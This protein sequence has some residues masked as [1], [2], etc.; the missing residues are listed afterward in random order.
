[1]VVRQYAPLDL[2]A[3]R[4]R[5]LS[6]KTTLIVGISLAVHAAVAGYLAM[7]QFAPPQAAPIEDPPVVQLDFYTPP[8]PPPPP[9]E[10]KAPQQPPKIQ[11]HTPVPSPL[12][13]PVAP[14]P[15][16]PT[17][18]P[19]RAI[20]PIASLTPPAPVNPPQPRIPVVSNPTWTKRPGAAELARF[21]PDRAVRMEQTGLATISCTVTDAGAVNDCRVLSET[22]E[23][24]GFGEAAV[25]LSK[26][27]RMSPR[28]VDGQAV[29]GAQVTI[30][31]RFTLGS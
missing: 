16:E 15:V 21:Y 28:T 6:P 5:R 31:I 14:L 18:E 25:K 30:P 20:D 2:I 7:M 1:M 13:S 23:R 9:P 27:F 24:F 3:P 17:P 11:I 4:G 8:K 12:P 10:T 29:G 19:V 22:P 26:Y